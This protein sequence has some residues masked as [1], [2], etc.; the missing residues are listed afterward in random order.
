MGLSLAAKMG[1]IRRSPGSRPSRGTDGSGRPLAASTVRADA[2][3]L[4]ERRVRIRRGSLNDP[5][6]RE[7]VSC[8]FFLTPRFEGAG[9]SLPTHPNYRRGACSTPLQTAGI[10]K[11]PLLRQ[12]TRGFD[13]EPS[14]RC[15]TP[16]DGFGGR[17]DGAVSSRSNTSPIFRGAALCPQLRYEDSKL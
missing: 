15:R 1:G 2:S 6:D 3:R 10:Q 7:I 5:P 9:V 4:T 17:Q 16:D 14:N 12:A 13:V 8:G 11:N